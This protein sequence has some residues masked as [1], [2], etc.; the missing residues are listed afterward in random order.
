MSNNNER[1]ARKEKGQSHEKIY[2]IMIWDV[3]SKLR[4]A[5]SF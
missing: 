5:N 1:R 2:E 4:F 3:L